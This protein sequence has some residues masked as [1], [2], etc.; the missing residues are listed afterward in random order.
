[1]SAPVRLRHTHTHMRDCGRGQWLNAHEVE[2]SARPLFSVEPP[3]HANNPQ[4]VTATHG[5]P[6]SVSMESPLATAGEPS[7]VGAAH[8]SGQGQL[9]TERP[10]LRAHWL[11]HSEWN[12]W[13]QRSAVVSS[14]ETIGNWQTMHLGA[15]SSAM[16]RRSAGQRPKP[17]N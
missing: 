1:M 9:A 11:I 12:A 14:P 5:G 8:L 7:T 13:A 10:L 15:S 6:N 4:L 3:N 16:A 17:I 2:R